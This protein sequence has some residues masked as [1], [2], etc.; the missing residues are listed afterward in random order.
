LICHSDN[1]FLGQLADTLD[2][3]ATEPCRPDG[4]GTLAG[5]SC[6][7]GDSYACRSCHGVQ[8][9]SPGTGVA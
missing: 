4:A 6:G 3:S 8:P 9:G 2:D 7:C 1:K 5:R